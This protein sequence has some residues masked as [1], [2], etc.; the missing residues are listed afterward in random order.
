[1]ND[2]NKISIKDFISTS[3]DSEKKEILYVTNKMNLELLKNSPLLEK[4]K[5]RNINVLL[6]N[7]EIDSLI[8]ANLNK[9][10]DYTFVNISEAKLEEKI[11]EK[12]EDIEEEYSDL[13]NKIQTIM[14]EEV[15]KV[16]LSFELTNSPINIKEDIDNQNYSL[17][18]MM[19]QVGQQIPDIEEP[20][21]ILEI[22][23]NHKIIKSLLN[24]ERKIIEDT[25][26]L[27]FDQNK[28]FLGIEIKDTISFAK[29]L[30]SLI[31]KTI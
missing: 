6:L 25:I 2:E 11:I 16:E 13:V 1:L 28:L 22:N 12:K 3:V 5:N 24:K 23:P 7:E 30:N 29:R 9:Y 14:K 21:P 20:K 4:F 8:F 27:L 26:K 17:Y 15:E 31:E 18:K 19:K 10:K